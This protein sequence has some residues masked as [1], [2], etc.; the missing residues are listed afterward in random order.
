MAN[1][2]ETRLALIPA[3]AGRSSSGYIGRTASMKVHVL[4][5]RAHEGPSWLQIH[6]GSVRSDENHS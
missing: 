6:R 3:L 1:H 5:A 4:F 2:N